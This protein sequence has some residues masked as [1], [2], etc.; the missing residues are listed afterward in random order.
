MTIGSVKIGKRSVGGPGDPPFIVAELSANH[1]GS[2]DA[3]LA[4]MDACAKAGADAIKLQTYTADTITIDCDRP[5]FHIDGGPW[6]GRSLHE[7]Y[8]E[9]HTPWDWHAALFEKG[10]SL[11]IEVFSSPFDHSAVD[12]LEQFDPPAYKIAS[13]EAID[14]PLIE[15]AASTGKPLVISSGMATHEELNDAVAAARRAGSG[16]MILLHCVSAYPAPV[17]EVNL[18]TIP[19]MQVRYGVPIGL[20]DHTIGGTVA[21]AAV[22]LG[23]AMVEK[24]VTMRRADGGPDS[25][26]SA[27]P[28]ELAKLVEDCR[29]A[30]LALGSPDVERTAA[31][32]ASVQ[33]RRSL[34]VVEDIAA[35]E[36]F[37]ERNVRSIR[38]GYG[39]PPKELPN[40][41][42]QRATV[43]LSRG[44]ALNSG[45]ITKVRD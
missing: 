8:D 23:A 7:L 45:H 18:T 40:V 20:S 43:D 11:G 5:E 19:A 12:F 35:G 6:A 21:V 27:E 42:G 3:A 38:P 32:T 25:H 22:A 44:T 29:T 4:I 39:L 31:E 33:F 28:E 2:L 37:T 9:A 26:F 30:A 24:H 13:F 34:Y 14:I 36:V 17:E 16:E 10:R 15:K 41:L 1:N